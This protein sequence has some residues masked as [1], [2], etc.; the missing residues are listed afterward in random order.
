MLTVNAAVVVGVFL[1]KI[2]LP[3]FVPDRVKPSLC[4]PSRRVV[5]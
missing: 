4:V 5:S 3:P 2:A 1:H